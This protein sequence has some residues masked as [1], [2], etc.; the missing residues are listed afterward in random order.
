M[1]KNKYRKLSAFITAAV[2]LLLVCIPGVNATQYIDVNMPS[3]L[4]IVHIQDGVPVAGEEF[5]LYKIASVDK[6]GEFTCLPPFD[7]YPVSIDGKDTLEWKGI[8]GA[9]E[10]YILRDSI[11]PVAAGITN[12]EGK[13][14]GDVNFAEVSQINL[15]Y[16]RRL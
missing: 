11:E 12:S 10:G 4:T 2:L 13:L 16:S 14:T 8:A 3:S 9:F 1:F 15:S 7:S 5:R 6:Y